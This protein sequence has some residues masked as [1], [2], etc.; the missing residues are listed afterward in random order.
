MSARL[1]DV[2]AHAGVSIESVSNVVHNHPHV[3]RRLR[4]R[5]QAS[6]DELGYRPDAFSAVAAHRVDRGQQAGGA[7][8]TPAYFAEIGHHVVTAAEQQGRTVLIVES[9]DPDRQAALLS[10]LRPTFLDGLIFSLHVVRRS[11]PGSRVITASSFTSPPGTRAFHG[12]C[13]CRCLKIGSLATRS[14][15]NWLM[16]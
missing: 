7:S 8:A 2:A 9:E 4:N 15:P 6:L 10:G 1:K 12:D 5:V 13:T 16:R 11:M 3:S 14:I